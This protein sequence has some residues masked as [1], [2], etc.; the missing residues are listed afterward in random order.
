VGVHGGALKVQVNA[1]P[2]EGAANRALI[3]VLAEWL[4]VPRRA[5]SVVQGSTRRDKVVE[6]SSDDPAGL[7]R[8]IEDAAGRVDKPRGAD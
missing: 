6:V 8:R 1:P 5:L 7:A 3:E 2:V 4:D